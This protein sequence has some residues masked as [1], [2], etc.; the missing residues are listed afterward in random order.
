MHML[1]QLM[2]KDVVVAVYEEVTDFDDCR[3]TL[4]EQLD[5]YLP[6]GFS[7]IDDWIDGRQ[8]AKHRVSIEKLIALK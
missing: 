1:Y 7:S 4:V 6:I 2:N 5:S 3:Y 8:V